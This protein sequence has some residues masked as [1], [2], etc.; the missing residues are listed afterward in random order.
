MLQGWACPP[1]SCIAQHCTRCP[2]L[3]NFLAETRKRVISFSMG[4]FDVEHLVEQV[5][6]DQWIK[7]TTSVPRGRKRRRNT[8]FGENLEI[9]KIMTKLQSDQ[10]VYPV[11]LAIVKEVLAPLKTQT[12][13]EIIGDEGYRKMVLLEA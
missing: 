10:L 4:H 5:V 12:V 2:V 6:K 11:Q 13:Q 8:N 7:T 3:N 9:R 1:R